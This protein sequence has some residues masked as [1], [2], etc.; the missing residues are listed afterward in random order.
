MHGCALYG[1]LFLGKNCTVHSNL[2]T[3]DHSQY[4]TEKKQSQGSTWW[5]SAVTN[6]LWPS[7]LL[8]CLVKTKPLLILGISTF[9]C[10]SKMKTRNQHLLPPGLFSSVT[11]WGPPSHPRALAPLEA[12]LGDLG[13]PTGRRGKGRGHRTQEAPQVRPPRWCWATATLQTRNVLHSYTVCGEMCV[14]HEGTDSGWKEPRRFAHKKI[15]TA[16]CLKTI[17]KRKS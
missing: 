2:L 16:I 7:H 4:T 6:T 3:L 8:F 15:I 17:Q 5:F 1:T 14:T 13:R 10:S 9:S 12:R 11:F